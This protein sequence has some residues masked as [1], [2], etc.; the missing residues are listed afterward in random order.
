MDSDRLL[1]LEKVMA[2]MEYNY[3]ST[4]QAHADRLKSKIVVISS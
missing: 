4:I 2:M 3:Q 1:N